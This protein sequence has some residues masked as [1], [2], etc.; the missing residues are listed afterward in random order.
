MASLL[1]ASLRPHAELLLKELQ[2]AAPLAGIVGQYDGY[3]MLK[4]LRARLSVPSSIQNISKKFHE[5]AWETMRDESLPNG[6]SS[7]QYTQKVNTL[8]KDHLPHFKTVSSSEW[9]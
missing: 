9:G 4:H 8:M 6:C 5:K 2:T 7:Q 3:E 1:A